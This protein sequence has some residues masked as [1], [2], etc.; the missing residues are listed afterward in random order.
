MEAMVI[1]IRVCEEPVMW[2]DKDASSQR[3]H[4]KK[5]MC[6]ADSNAH[7]R[8]FLDRVVC[9]VSLLISVRRDCLAPARSHLSLYAVPPA[10]R[11]S[12][13][14]SVHQ[15]SLCRMRPGTDV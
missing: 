5:W 2:H 11:P 15:E 6:Y 8:L 12:P 4:Q 14:Q 10:E 3:L 9:L 13:R 7:P 1:P